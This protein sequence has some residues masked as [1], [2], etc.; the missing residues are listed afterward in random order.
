MQLLLHP[1]S[2]ASW[3]GDRGRYRWVGW[4]V[5]GYRGIGTEIFRGLGRIARA[6]AE[7]ESIV[8]SESDSAR[9]MSSSGYVS[10]WSWCDS[11]AFSGE[12]VRIDGI[13]QL[14]EVVWS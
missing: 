1:L 7:S 3:A 14:A 6:G 4:V 5:L 11:C 13:I 8:S 2:R 10:K 12:V 9:S